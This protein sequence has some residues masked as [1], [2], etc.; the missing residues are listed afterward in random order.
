MDGHQADL[1]RKLG[2]LGHLVQGAPTPEGLAV[3]VAELCGRRLVRYVPG[4]GAGVAS[5]VDRLVGRS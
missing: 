4:S 2:E 3:A 1:T 5:H